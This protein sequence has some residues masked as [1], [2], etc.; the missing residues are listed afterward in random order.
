[1]SGKLIVW[2]MATILP[3]TVSLAQAQ[4]AK[5]LPRVGFLV[6][7]TASSISAR[8]EGLRELGYAESQNILIDYRYAEGKFDRVTDLA[9]ELVNSQVESLSRKIIQRRLLHQES[10]KPF[11]WSSR[12][13]LIPWLLG[14]LRALLDP[15]EMSLGWEI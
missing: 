7:G 3:A 4:Q 5:K 13:G 12:M 2:L 8:K 9:A 14:S 1:M 10:P 11:L 15:V 6:P